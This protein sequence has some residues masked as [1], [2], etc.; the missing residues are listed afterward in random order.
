MCMMEDRKGHLWFGTGNGLDKYDGYRFRHFRFD[1]ADPSSLPKNQVISLWEDSD[2]IIWV[3]TT[4]GTCSFDPLTEKFTRLERGP[5]NPY[6]F[7]YA[8]SFNQDAEGNLWVGGSFTGELRQ[9]ERKTGRFSVVNY[10]DMLKPDAGSG[11]AE[12]FSLIILAKDRAGTLW[13]GSPYGLHRLSLTP[14]G[15]GEPADVSFTNYRHDP[16]DPN[17]LSHNRVTGIHEDSKGVMWVGT[18]GGGLNAFDQKKGKFTRFLP[19]S[20]K[21]LETGGEL[22]SG[23]TEDAAGNLWIGSSQGLYRADPE[24]KAF[25]LFLHDPSYIQSISANHVFAVLRDKAGILWVATPEGVNKLD[26]HRKPFRLF[27][28]DPHKPG[29]LSHNRVSWSCYIWLE[30]FI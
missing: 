14:C 21:P 25:S 5:S 13:V 8:Q 3:G 23:I 18:H 15:K 6:A 12:G 30:T 29:S 28:H 1:P 26:P 10:A 16:A 27:R 7:K 19:A 9:I 24:R 17:S 20:G 22:R 2:G 4:E 11:A